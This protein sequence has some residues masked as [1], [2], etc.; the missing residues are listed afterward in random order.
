MAEYLQRLYQGRPTDPSGELLFEVPVL[1]GCIVKHVEI[2]NVEP[3]YGL[4]DSITMWVVPPSDSPADDL[5]WIPETEVGPSERL[6]WGGGDTMA[7]ES[8]CSVWA[9]SLNGASDA[10]L[11]VLITGMLVDEQ[12]QG[13]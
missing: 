2:I 13:T 3:S 8:G 7:L 1:M 9:A 5:I 4:S 12:P 6:T 10:V 11:N